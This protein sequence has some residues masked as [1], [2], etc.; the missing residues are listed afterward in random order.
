MCDVLSL[1]NSLLFLDDLYAIA[2]ML[3]FVFFCDDLL[4]S[5]WDIF[6]GF[7]GL[8]VCCCCCWSG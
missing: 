4:F 7:I 6:V 1:Y 3:F 8:F 5:F 2:D